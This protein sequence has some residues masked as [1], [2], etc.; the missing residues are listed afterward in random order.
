MGAAF[1]FFDAQ[2]CKQ[3]GGVFRVMNV[4]AGAAV[5]Q[6][7]RRRFVRFV[8]VFVERAATDAERLADFGRAATAGGQRLNR[9]CHFQKTT[10]P[11]IRSG[12]RLRIR[13][14]SCA[15]AS[16]N[17]QAVRL[18]GRYVCGGFWLRD[19]LTWRQIGQVR[20]VRVGPFSAFLDTPNA[21][22]MA[23]T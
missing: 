7:F 15:E 6:R 16:K 1:C 14:K 20:A 11:N 8:S 13:K 2:L 5:S 18:T 12:G 22:S 21:G 9:R 19:A 23:A 10:A 17:K 4:Y 3:V